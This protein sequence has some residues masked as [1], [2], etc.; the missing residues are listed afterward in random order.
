MMVAAVWVEGRG[1]QT[2]S[3]FFVFLGS[4][5]LGSFSQ[6]VK[7]KVNVSLQGLLLT[8]PA[9]KFFILSRLQIEQAA[10]SVSS[11]DAELS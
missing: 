4:L 9:A 1:W 10:F 2:T 7:W 3:Y 11:L 6:S 5:W 8:L